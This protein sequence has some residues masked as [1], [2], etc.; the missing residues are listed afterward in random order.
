MKGNSA[1]YMSFYQRDTWY[2]PS[3]CSVP[4][5]PT[6]LF[7]FPPPPLILQ[8]LLS[9]SYEASETDGSDNNAR[10]A[11]STGGYDEFGFKKI[12]NGFYSQITNSSWD[13][14]SHHHEESQN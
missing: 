14:H 13:F 11:A 6:N 8:K 4:C 9:L 1:N 2:T 3:R 5:I 7:G 12:E 10:A